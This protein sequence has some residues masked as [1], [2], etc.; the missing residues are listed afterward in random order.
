MISAVSPYLK[1][2]AALLGGAAE[3]GL[4]LFAPHSVP[5]VVAELIVAAATAAAVYRV[6]YLPGA[7]PAPATPPTEGNPS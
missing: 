1:F 4:T 7:D 3:A 6:P 2:L 5:W